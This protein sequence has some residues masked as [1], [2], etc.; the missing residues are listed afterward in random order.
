MYGLFAVQGV[1]LFLPGTVIMYRV[2][3]RQ[4]YIRYCWKMRNPENGKNR[5]KKEKR[6]E[7]CIYDADG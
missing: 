6:H 4:A 2:F 7:T 3:C 5:K 1:F